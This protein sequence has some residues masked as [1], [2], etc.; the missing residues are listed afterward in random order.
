MCKSVLKVL[1]GT[2]Y[3]SAVCGAA[4]SNAVEIKQT[5][6]SEVKEKQIESPVVQGKQV[7]PYCLPRGGLYVGLGT[8]WGTFTTDYN[9][10][11]AE[12]SHINTKTVFHSGIH[13]DTFGGIGFCL[14]GSDFYLGVELRAATGNYEGRT[15]AMVSHD[16]YLI[17]DL[18]SRF[19]SELAG[20]IGYR[21]LDDSMLY[22]RVGLCLLH[23]SNKQRCVEK[24]T[25][26]IDYAEDQSA[27]ALAGRFGLGLETMLMD[28]HVIRLEVNCTISAPENAKSVYD[29]HSGNEIF[30]GKL[31][32]RVMEASIQYVV[33][34]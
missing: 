8:G 16:L 26:E 33:P 3:F 30:K 6:R 18:K 22:A 15:E 12:D 32:F 31:Q 1:V 13:F 29:D 24:E 2:A 10:A 21:I 19:S 25:D 20:R 9:D 11:K 7:K 5:K 17:Q 27:F 34:F 4:T 23:F 28:R 14:P